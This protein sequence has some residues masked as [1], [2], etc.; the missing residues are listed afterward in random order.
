MNLMEECWVKIDFALLLDKIWLLNQCRN[1]LTR[2]MCYL[3]NERLSSNI[4]SVRK[5]VFHLDQTQTYIERSM[6]DIAYE[7]LE[8]KG[9][10]MI[11]QDIMK[12]VAEKK[13]FSQ[14]EVDEMIAQLYTE[15]NIDG[16][17]I[18][19]G[20]NL[21]GLKSWFPIE[22]ATDSAVAANVKEDDFANE[23][24]LEDEE[25]IDEEIDSEDYGLEVEDQD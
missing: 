7:L 25:E 10:P 20:R 22:Q 8:Q 24:E 3:L 12:E 15:I 4:V 14:Q 19:V 5:E 1:H 23:A 13:G 21:W 18:C 6:V 17:F 11:Y 2:G 16:R 9:E